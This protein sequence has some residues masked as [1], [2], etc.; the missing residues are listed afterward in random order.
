[1]VIQGTQ[2]SIQE[3]L[4]ENNPGIRGFAIEFS[5]TANLPDRITYAIEATLDD[6]QTI[7]TSGGTINFN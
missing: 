5:D 1:M 4:L 2:Q 7:R 3:Y 6:G